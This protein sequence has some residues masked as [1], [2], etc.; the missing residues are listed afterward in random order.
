MINFLIKKEKPVI[1]PGVISIIILIIL[2]FL[3]V[4][5]LSIK[6]FKGKMLNNL[7]ENWEKNP[8]TEIEIIDGIIT[9]DAETIDKYNGKEIKI[10]NG[11]SFKIKR[12]LNLNYYKMFKKKENSKKCGVDSNNNELYVDKNDECPINEISIIDKEDCDEKNKLNNGKCLYYSNKNING[13]VLININ[14]GKNEGCG[15]CYYINDYCKDFDLSLCKYRNSTLIDSLFISD[16]IK[17][18]NLPQNNKN[19]SIKLYSESY[20]YFDYS[21]ERLGKI[22]ILGKNLTFELITFFFFIFSGICILVILS[23]D[24][25]KLTIV[26]SIFSVIFSLINLIL[27]III[28]KDYYKIS[29]KIIPEISHPIKE[30]FVYHT[31]YEINDTIIIFTIVYLILNVIWTILNHLKLNTFLKNHCHLKDVKA[32]QE[33]IVELNKIVFEGE[34]DKKSLKKCFTEIEN[35]EETIDLSEENG[36]TNDKDIENSSENS[37]TTIII[38]SKKNLITNSKTISY[39]NNNSLNNQNT[40]SDFQEDNQK[41]NNQKSLN[42]QDARNDDN[43]IENSENDPN[44]SNPE[45]IFQKNNYDEI[46]K[47][48]LYKNK[49][50]K[51]LEELFEKITAPA[52]KNN[53]N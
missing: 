43:I 51:L 20:I 10:W 24:N 29:T 12:N 38:Y 19:D 13:N 36:S 9:S 40:I 11:K 44:N 41:I 21:N 28:N 33:A 26:L 47:E 22:L 2:F 18:N 1:I 14:V 37:Q 16:Y 42:F 27:L 7:K 50:Y 17:D 46:F 3:N 34:G 32:L 6:R 30:K 49:I 4:S 39:T 5:I 23:I 8:I 48:Y 25:K 35:T 53:N 15:I 45:N 31:S 52:R